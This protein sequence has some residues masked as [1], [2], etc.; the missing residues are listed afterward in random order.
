MEGEFKVRAVEFEE[1]SKVEIEEKLLKEHEDKLRQEQDGTQEPPSPEPTPTPD[2]DDNVVL[3]HLK[4]RYNREISSLDELFEQ[5]NQNEELPEDV[6][7]FLKYKKETGR[8]INDFIKLN[9]DYSNAEPDTLIFDYYKDQNPDLDPDDVR[10]EIG[11]K[12]GYDEDLDEE[13]EVKQKKLAFKKELTKA[14]KYFDDLKD[15][16][17][18]P[19]ES[20][21]PFVSEEDKESYDSFKSYKEAATQHEMEQVKRSKFFAEKTSEL[22]S[23][24]FEGFGFNIDENNKMVYKP[25]DSNT[26]I[27]EQSNIMDFVSKFLNEDGYLKNAESFHKAIAVANNPDRFAKYFYEKGKADAVGNIAKESKNIDMTRTAPTPT[28]KE[29]PQVRIIDEERGNR[30]IIRKPF[31]N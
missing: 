17:K 25:A 16:Y 5:R 29:G 24:K 23:D 20:R 14:K 6:A 15:Q 18:V 1:K 13:R 30:L 22:F 2:I 31:K 11:L 3:S 28:P 12:F 26:L 4:T 27:K 9:K 8:N 10:F 19:L 21:A 7:A